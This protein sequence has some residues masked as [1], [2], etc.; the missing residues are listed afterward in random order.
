MA[1]RT[2]AEVVKIIHD[3][4]VLY[5]KNLVN[6]SLLFV[7]KLNDV[8]NCFETV[9]FSRNFMHLTGVDSQLKGNLFYY[10]ALNNRLG[11][12]DI[13]IAADGKTDQKLDVL[14]QLMNI[15]QIARMVG[16]YDISRP[17]LIADKL[18]GT[19][20]TA[21]GFIKVNNVV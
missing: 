19:V 10:A 11:T 9:F 13:T 14:P 16:D 18:A 12:S 15:H 1:K 2:K 20:T 4:A 5:S 8:A 21:M 3:C 17:L 7:T 6:K